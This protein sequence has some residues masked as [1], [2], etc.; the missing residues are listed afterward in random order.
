LFTPRQGGN[1]AALR[2]KR[3]VVWH[4]VV[5]DIWEDCWFY[6]DCKWKTWSGQEIHIHTLAIKSPNAPPNA[7]PIPPA[8]TVFTGQDSIAACIW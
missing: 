7:K 4:L 8:M 6:T 3:R 1:F 2:R 5:T